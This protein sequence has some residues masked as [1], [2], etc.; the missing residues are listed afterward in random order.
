MRV[1]LCR[2]KAYRF[3]ILNDENHKKSYE[4]GK[5]KRP[6]NEVLIMPNILWSVF[7]SVWAIKK[8]LLY[9]SHDNLLKDLQEVKS[10]CKLAEKKKVIL[11]VGFSKRFTPPYVNCKKIIKNGLIGKISQITAKMC[12]GW[13]KSN[14]L[15]NQVCY[16]IDIMSFLLGSDYKCVI[17][18]AKNF[19]SKPNYPIDG[20]VA[21][22][23]FQ[24]GVLGTL[25]VN[26]TSPSLKP[27]ER[28]E[29]F[30][31]QKWVK[32]DDSRKLVLYDSNEGPTKTWEPVWPNTLLMDTHFSGFVGEITAF[33]D[34]VQVISDPITSGW[35]GFKA[36]ELAYALHMSYKMK[37]EVELPL[38]I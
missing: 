22:L 26:S 6:Q 20:L 2:K 25:C 37:K 35:D 24:N 30:G 21:L 29:V 11:S 19:Y 3:V 38:D 9:S 23:E 33:L 8:P 5:I 4:I 32:I 12:Q 36:L 1:L 10:L 7:F 17:S 27:W 18:R 14:F 31:D 28:I 15:E 13:F 16:I 34:A